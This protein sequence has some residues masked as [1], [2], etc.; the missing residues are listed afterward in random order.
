M[1][2]RLHL[3]IFCVL[4]TFI[5]NVGVHCVSA[6]VYAAASW[7]K[8]A[9]FYEMCFRLAGRGSA[10]RNCPLSCNTVHYWPFWERLIWKTLVSFLGVCLLSYL[11]AAGSLPRKCILRVFVSCTL[12]WTAVET[13]EQP[14]LLTLPY[15]EC[16]IAYQLTR[17]ATRRVT[18]LTEKQSKNPKYE[19]GERSPVW[20]HQF[21]SLL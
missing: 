6:C 9:L 3:Y 7:F 18:S 12:K 20:R 8:R 10:L 19:G 2:P 4:E 17:N 14:R 16:C 11:L 5:P 13:A 1:V 21:L 15:L